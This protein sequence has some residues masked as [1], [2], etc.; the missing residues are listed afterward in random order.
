MHGPIWEKVGTLSSSHFHSINSY[1]HDLNISLISSPV[2]IE[3]EDLYNTFDHVLPIMKHKYT[4][5]YFELL[6]PVLE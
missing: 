5:R 3:S 6:S 1:L 2:M 4:R